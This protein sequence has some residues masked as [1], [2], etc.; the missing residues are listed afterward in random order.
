MSTLAPD[1]PFEV[2]AWMTWEYMH[3]P[4]FSDMVASL[5]ASALWDAGVKATRFDGYREVI[6]SKP[7]G[8]ARLYVL[9]GMGR[10]R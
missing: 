5:F 9:S 2:R 8:S 3:D 6:D 1:T 10:L 7:E 4:K